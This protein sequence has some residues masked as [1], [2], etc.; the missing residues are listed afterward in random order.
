MIQTKGPSDVA[1]GVVV[2]FLLLVAVVVYSPD[3]WFLCMIAMPLFIHA[4][5]DCTT[6]TMEAQG[7]AVSIFGW[8]QFY[9]WDE[10]QTIRFL[11]FGRQRF[12]GRNGQ[13]TYC[14]GVLFCKK[15]I[16]KYPHSIDPD[17]YIFLHHPFSLSCFYIQFT[18][19]NKY[20]ITLFPSK[21]D[22]MQKELPC[23]YPVDRAS[24]LSCIEKW[25]V[26]VEGLNAPYPPEKVE[27]QKKRR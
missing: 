9:S 4:M 20:A 5:H 15:R 1:I 23:F 12:S 24:F 13:I 26:K 27:Q 3:L 21:G 19:T 22:K 17:T 7:C 18:P 10:L 16:K 2:A 6:I 8:K 14:E 25:G 11:D